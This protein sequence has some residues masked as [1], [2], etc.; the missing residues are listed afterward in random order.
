MRSKKWLIL[1]FYLYLLLSFGY[2]SYS[3]YGRGDNFWV[4]WGLVTLVILYQVIRFLIDKKK[5]GWNSSYVV[6]DHRILGKLKLSLAI[7]YVFIMVFLLVGVLGINQGIFIF[8]PFEMMVA[9]MIFSLLVF[10]IAQIVQ[11]FI[12]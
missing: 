1:I 9:A 5:D 3:A 7:S 8:D 11:Q 10:M 4:I 6:A 12:N 2:T